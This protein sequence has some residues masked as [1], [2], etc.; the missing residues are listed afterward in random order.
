MVRKTLEIKIQKDSD[1]M[2]LRSYLGQELHFTR[3]QISSL[4][5]R[6]DGILVNGIRA[7]VNQIL[8]EG[9]LLCLNLKDDANCSPQLIP[10]EEMPDILYEDN[11]IVCVD[12]P[13]GL[14][15]HPSPG[16]YQDSSGGKDPTA[17]GRNPPNGG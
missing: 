9:D 1:G 14:V 8:R 6:N 10:A 12:K 4:K 3:A 13:A 15:V 5:F 2:Q 7:R 16:H 17:P 11:D